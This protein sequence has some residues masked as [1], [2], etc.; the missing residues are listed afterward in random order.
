LLEGPQLSVKKFEKYCKSK[1]KNKETELKDDRNEI[2][3]DLNEISRTTLLLMVEWA[4][5][6]HP[7]PELSME[8]KVFIFSKSWECTH[9]STIVIG[10]VI[11]LKNYAPQHLILMPAFR[12]PDTTRLCLFNN[13]LLGADGQSNGGA[14]DQQLGSFAAFKAANIM[15]RVLDEIVWPM[16]QLEVCGFNGDSKL[17]KE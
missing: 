8:D 2:A 13:S 1:D 3:Q 14:D 12:S 7:F 9:P 15:P 11:L 17:K 16:R 6:M 4:K 10:Q 5:G